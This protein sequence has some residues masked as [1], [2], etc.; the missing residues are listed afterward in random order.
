[1]PKIQS[2]SPTSIARTTVTTMTTIERTA[3]SDARTSTLNHMIAPVPEYSLTMPQ[4]MRCVQHLPKRTRPARRGEFGHH[5]FKRDRGPDELCPNS[6]RGNIPST[7]IVTA[8]QLR[9]K[10]GQKLAEKARELGVSVV[11]LSLWNAEW[12]GS[13]YDPDYVIHRA[14]HNNWLR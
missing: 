9:M 10:P 7:A 4:T 13:G 3:Q 2:N 1:V 6:A 8:D 5:Q 11:T 14:G 12:R